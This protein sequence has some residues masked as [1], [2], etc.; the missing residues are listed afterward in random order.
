MGSRAGHTLV[1][2][3]SS[4]STHVDNR[5]TDIPARSHYV[6]GTDIDVCLT[7]QEPSLSKSKANAVSIVDAKPER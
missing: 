6:T 5:F 3:E 2:R 4:N 7:S 1:F